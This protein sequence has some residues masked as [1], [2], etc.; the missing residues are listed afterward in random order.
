LA[1]SNLYTTSDART[2]ALNY[3]AATEMNNHWWAPTAHPK[4]TNGTIL[5]TVW[6][7]NGKTPVNTTIASP[8]VY[9]NWNEK[10]IDVQGLSNWLDTWEI[11]YYY[12]AQFYNQVLYR[13][14]ESGVSNLQ[15]DTTESGQVKYQEALRVIESVGGWETIK[16]SGVAAVSN[17]NTASIDGRFVNKYINAV[18]DG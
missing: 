16:A 3:V 9:V 12:Y 13:M 15:N 10:V 7:E 8:H 2:L 14:L 6:N 18:K 4:D 17:N 1:S 5:K 11:Y